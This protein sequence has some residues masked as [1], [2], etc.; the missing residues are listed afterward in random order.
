MRKTINFTLSAPADLDAVRGFEAPSPCGR[1][2]FVP[3]SAV[4]EDYAQ[5]LVDADGVSYEEARQ[6]IEE[7]G[8]D[9]LTTWFYEQFD[10]SDVERYGTLTGAPSMQQ[11]IAALNLYRTWVGW[12]PA[13]NCV[14]RLSAQSAAANK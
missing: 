14:E 13:N 8:E 1:T 7:Y 9:T 10:W 12:G 5:F 4:R 3:L 11:V 6:K 2:W